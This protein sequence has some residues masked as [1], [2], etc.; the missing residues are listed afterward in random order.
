MT[1]HHILYIQSIS[2]NI[3][4][5]KLIESNLYWRG[6]LRSIQHSEYLSAVLYTPGHDA[7]FLIDTNVVHTAPAFLSGTTISMSP[8]PYTVFEE[9]NIP[10]IVSRYYIK[11]WLNP[12]NQPAIELSERYLRWTTMKN[13]WQIYFDLEVGV[14]SKTIFKIYKFNFDL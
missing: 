4:A 5:P 8:M 10:I 12:A 11:S 13:F 7:A 3:C 9:E 2:C 6:F 14:L 1:F